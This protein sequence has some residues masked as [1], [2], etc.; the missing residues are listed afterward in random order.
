M[1]DEQPRDLEKIRVDKHK[2]DAILRK[3]ATCEPLPRKDL[4][5]TFPKK[6]KEQKTK[7]K[8]RSL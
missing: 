6:R 1:T 5:G 8:Y 3:M 7:K 2:F 4:A